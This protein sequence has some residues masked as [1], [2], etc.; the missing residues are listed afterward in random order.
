[1]FNFQIKCLQ[2]AIAQILEIKEKLLK[3]YFDLILTLGFFFL[4]FAAVFQKF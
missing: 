4:F 1:M 2:K 3:L